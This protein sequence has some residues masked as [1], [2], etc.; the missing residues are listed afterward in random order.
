MPAAGGLLVGGLMAVFGL[1]P[2]DVHG[3]LHYAGVMDPL[4]GGTRSVHAL[5]VGDLMEAWRYNPISFPL[6]FGAAGVLVRQVVGLGAG[7]WV[8]VSVADRKV[9]WA[10]VTVLLVALEVNQQLHADLLRTS[11]GRFWFVVPLIY[12]LA[13]VGSYLLARR[14]WRAGRPAAPGFGRSGG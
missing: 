14:Q 10:V 8:N 1:P 7:W 5:M 11:P 6:V 3:P 9:F 13:G 4:C 12:A 2:V